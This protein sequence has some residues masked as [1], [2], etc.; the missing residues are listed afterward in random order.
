MTTSCRAS[1]L[2]T[3]SSR[4]D[5]DD[6][7]VLPEEDDWFAT[8]FQEPV[9]TDEVAWQDDEPAPPPRAAPDGLAQRQIVIVLAVLAIIAAIV[10]LILLVKAVR[11]SDSP[12]A[13]TPV[14]TATTPADTTPANTTPADT[15]PADT[16]PADT[17]PTDTTT[18][19]TGGDVTSVP[20]EATL[21]AGTTGSSVTDLQNAL[22]QLG[23]DAGTAD[24][25]YGAATTAAVTAFQKDKG[26]TQDGT[27]GPTTLAA[28]NTALAA[29]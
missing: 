17:T 28:I 14:T 16:T 13:N 6:L 29:G 2:W 7:P 23:Y 22:N 20:T 4:Y 10:I 25:N 15:T 3:V 21:R 11:G 18:T 8:P 9:E 12:P 26:L 27:A 1:N 19:P 5:S 24:G